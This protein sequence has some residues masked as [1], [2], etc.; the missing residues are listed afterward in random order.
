VSAVLVT[1]CEADVVIAGFSTMNTLLGAS[2][3]TVVSSIVAVGCTSTLTQDP[4]APAVA[5]P[6]KAQPSETVSTWV[7]PLIIPTTA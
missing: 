5:P 4:T 3:S 7:P 2:L 1:V 6:A